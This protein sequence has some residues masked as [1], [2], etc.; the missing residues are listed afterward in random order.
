MKECATKYVIIPTEGNLIS[1]PSS[2]KKA[3]E[4]GQK[5]FNDDFIIRVMK[6][7]RLD[8]WYETCDVYN[9]KGIMIAKKGQ[10]L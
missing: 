4:V 3:V 2:L 6:R 8:E 5:N 9:S 1:V 7:G 10:T